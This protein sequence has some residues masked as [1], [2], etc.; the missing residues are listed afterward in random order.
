V[1]IKI[2]PQ[3]GFE[4]KECDLLEMDIASWM[5]DLRP[6][7]IVHCA[8]NANVSIS[9][10]DPGFDFRAGV[11]LLHR[12]LFGVRDAGV[13]PSVVFFSSAAV[14]GNPA[15]LPITE[16]A[17]AQPISPYG[18]HKRQCEELCEYFHRVEGIPTV[19]AR[20]FSA[21]GAGLRKQL[22]WDL[23]NKILKGTDVQLFGT[24]EETRDFIHADDVVQAVQLLASAQTGGIYNLASGEELSIRAV[25]S[26]LAKG[27]GKDPAILSFNGQE[28]EGDPKNWRADVTR[29]KAIGYQKTVT[30]ENGLNGYA[31]W[32]LHG[33]H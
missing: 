19:V 16:D 2:I 33:R 8:G 22:F 17:K 10:S 12:L 31:E 4:Q 18:L 13:K 6:D 15:A 30:I 1:D 21:Y 9:V 3:I 11:S 29:L 7:V 5:R 23:S 25:A 27:L 20:I 24:G 26:I 14:Y 28:K 32:V